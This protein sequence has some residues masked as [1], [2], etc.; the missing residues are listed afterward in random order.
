MAKLFGGDVESVRFDSTITGDPPVVADG[1]E[2]FDYRRGIGGGFGVAVV[3]GVWH[4]ER[5]GW[6]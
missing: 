5:D 3:V 1:V 6:Q 2:C 4:V